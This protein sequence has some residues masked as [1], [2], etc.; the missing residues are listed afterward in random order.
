MVLERKGTHFSSLSHTVKTR[1]SKYFVPII[2]EENTERGEDDQNQ[3]NTKSED[4][5]DGFRLKK[6]Y[7]GLKL[8]E[9]SKDR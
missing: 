6:Y 1:D 2:W 8:Y 5:D 4:G 9:L 3:I 7:I